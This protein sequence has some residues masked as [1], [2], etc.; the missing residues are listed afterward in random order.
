MSLA[1]ET[2]TTRNTVKFIVSPIVFGLLLVAGFLWLGLGGWVFFFYFT[3]LFLYSFVWIVEVCSTAPGVT[4][5]EDLKKPSSVGFAIYMVLE[6]VI[7][8]LWRLT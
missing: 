6:F 4:M 2:F 5:I 8:A 7:C 3:G 1:K